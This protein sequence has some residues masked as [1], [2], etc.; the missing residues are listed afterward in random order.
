MAQPLCGKVNIMIRWRHHPPGAS[1]TVDVTGWLDAPAATFWSRV[2]G[3][4]MLPL[5][6]G[7]G[8]VYCI[9]TQRGILIGQLWHKLNGLP[10]VALGVACL[11]AGIFFHAHYFWGPVS[12]L[13]I[14]FDL[15]RIIGVSVFILGFGYV[16]W[17]ILWL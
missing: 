4:M 8:G 7:L 16:I 1:E 14:V 15:G 11:G 9:V 5:L 13:P 2:F 17:S 12:R 3:G 10:A 6:L